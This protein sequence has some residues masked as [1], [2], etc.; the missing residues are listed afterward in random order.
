MPAAFGRISK[1]KDLI[2]ETLLDASKETLEENWG[3]ALDGRNKILQWCELC[4]TEYAST[5]DTLGYQTAV[6][7][8]FNIFGF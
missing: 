6:T 5:K 2:T 4:A 3:I 7:I 8:L 1:H